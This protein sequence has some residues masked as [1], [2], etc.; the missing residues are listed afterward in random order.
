M[1]RRNAQHLARTDTELMFTFKNA[2]NPTHRLLKV[3]VLGN[4][5]GL[6]GRVHTR[7]TYHRTWETGLE[8][9][10]SPLLPTPIFLSPELRTSICIVNSFLAIKILST[11]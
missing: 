3:I 9:A 6:A 7:F 2:F 1:G 8:V 5:V 11:E 10:A 4:L